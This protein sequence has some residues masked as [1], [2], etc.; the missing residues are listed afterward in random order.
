VESYSFPLTFFPAYQKEG[1]IWVR[2]GS[3]RTTAT[4]NVY[5][6]F[7]ALAHNIAKR[8]EINI[9]LIKCIYQNREVFTQG[10]LKELRKF[11]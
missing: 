1:R 5:R 6:N 7:E 8:T 3:R 11:F 4:Q 10:T 2:F 9:A